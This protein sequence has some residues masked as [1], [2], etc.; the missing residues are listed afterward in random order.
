M[1]SRKRRL[2]YNRAQFWLALCALGVSISLAY[3]TIQSDWRIAGDSGSLRKPQL[4]F[5]LGGILLL[6]SEETRIL[7]GARK[8][9]DGKAVVIA[10]IPF[11][12]YN[13]GD[14]TLENASVTFRFHKMFQRDVL[15]ELEFSS[16]GSFE[17]SQVGRSFTSGGELQY[18]SYLIPALNPR[19]TLGVAEP[20]FLPHTRFADTMPVE[21][22]DEE[23]ITLK[24]DFEFGLEFLVSVTARDIPTRDYPFVL[25]TAQTESLDGLTQY[26]ADTRIVRRLSE[27]RENATFGQY[28]KALVFG[29]P[30]ES[31]FLVFAELD[32]HPVAN[33]AL[34][35]GRAD[36]KVRQL[37]YS[38]VSWRWLFQ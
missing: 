26:A 14:A 35:F 29:V 15:E 33:G 6:P 3:V 36:P 22:A 5:G 28:L 13:A 8:L 21:T 30:D 27:A 10:N 37:S 11:S 32:E 38:P 24:V 16:I 17:A 34:Y 7:F 2:D 31:L 4:A 19:Q 23:T 1:A 18:S 25:E 12:I 9:S 20:I